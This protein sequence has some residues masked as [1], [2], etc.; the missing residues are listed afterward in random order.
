MTENTS[1]EK[2]MRLALEQAQC[3]QQKDDVPVGCVIVHDSTQT[4]V[5]TAHN[6]REM[7]QD[8][9]AHAELTAIQLACQKRKAWRLLDCSLYVTLEP[10]IMCAGA[11]LL[12]RIPRVI[13]GCSDPKAGA[14]QCLYQ[15]LNDSRLNHQC[16]VMPGILETESSLILKNFFS[17]RRKKKGDNKN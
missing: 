11:I 15:T 2:W 9:T 3:A 16:E 8:A 17:A 13:Y 4:I 6:A 5:A 1:H 7:L 12:A 10:C 14:V